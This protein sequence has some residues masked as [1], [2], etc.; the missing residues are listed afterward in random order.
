MTAEEHLTWFAENIAWFEAIALD[1]M[2][3]HVPACPGWNIEH[4]LNHLSYGL[5][6][7]YPSALDVAPDGDLDAAFAGVPWPKAYPEG[8]DAM[9]EFR[10]NLG[11]CLERFRHVDPDKRCVTYEGPGTA[12]F[13]FRRAAIETTLHRF[14]VA[15][16]LTGVT[17]E[18]VDERA[19]DMIDDAVHFALPLAASIAGPVPGRV[20]LLVDDERRFELGAGEPAAVVHGTA[21]DLACGLWGRH[22]DDLRIDG[23]QTTVNGWFSLV[24]VAFAGR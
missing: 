5:G 12:S 19:H 1:D 14:D 16:A 4:V 7:A 11:S 6:L 3:T 24:E 10:R 13:W 15:E 23:D 18:L 22:R 21:S 9:T 8:I 17:L 2:A 20:I